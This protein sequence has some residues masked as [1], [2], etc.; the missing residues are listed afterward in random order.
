MQTLT[1]T[2]ALTGTFS[3]KVWDL[4]SGNN[5]GTP[6]AIAGATYTVDASSGR[7]T[8]TNAGGNPPIVYL[9]SPAAK[10]EPI[11]AFCRRDGHHGAARRIGVPAECCL[12]DHNGA[13]VGRAAVV[14]AEL[15]EAYESAYWINLV[16]RHASCPSCPHLY[17]RVGQLQLFYCV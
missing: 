10:S 6:N 16:Y 12:D 11:S 1:P 13:E 15:T 2:G 4:V 9:A 5:L 3:G 7:V 8:F 17:R 14:G